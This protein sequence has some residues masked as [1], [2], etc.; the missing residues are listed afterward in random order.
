ME[1]AGCSSRTKSISPRNSQGQKRASD[2][3]PGNKMLPERIISRIT[4]QASGSRDIENDILLS[5]KKIC[6]TNFQ[7][8]DYKNSIANL[9][10]NLVHQIV[11]FKWNML[12]L[13]CYTDAH[14]DNY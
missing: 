14:I 5:K 12:G 11:K 6:Y 13:L 7:R 4:P 1:C 2:Q 9:V 3:E 8:F 10:P